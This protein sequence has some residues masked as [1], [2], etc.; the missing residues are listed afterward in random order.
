MLYQAPRNTN[1]YPVK[2][3]KEILK[4][5]GIKGISKYNTTNYLNELTCSICNEEYLKRK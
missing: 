2:K 4:K 1:V 3:C 5:K